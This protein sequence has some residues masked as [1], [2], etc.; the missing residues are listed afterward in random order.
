MLSWLTQHGSVGVQGALASL[1]PVCVAQ[2]PAGAAED[3]LGQNLSCH[4][5]EEAAIASGSP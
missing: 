2:A 3:P 4:Q 1:C 5:G